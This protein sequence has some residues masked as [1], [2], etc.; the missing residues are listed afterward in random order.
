MGAATA[1]DFT[2]CLVKDR[3]NTTRTRRG[4]NSVIYLTVGQHITRANDHRFLL[5]KWFGFIFNILDSNL[6]SSEGRRSC[7]HTSRSKHR[8]NSAVPVVTVD[9]SDERPAQDQRNARTGF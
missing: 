4:R 6:R 9:L 2:P 3:S 1:F 8:A 7:R 5:A